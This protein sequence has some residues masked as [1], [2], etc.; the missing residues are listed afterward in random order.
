MTKLAV[1]TSQILVLVLF[2]AALG[3]QLLILPGIAAQARDLNPQVAYLYAPFLA[4]CI[5]VIACGQIVLASI[6][7]LLRLVDRDRIFTK[8]AFVWV[9]I[10]IA[11]LLLATALAG[12]MFV[13]QNVVL[14]LG[15]PPLLTYGLLAVMV[16]STTL[17]LVLVALRGLLRKASDHA[18]YLEEVV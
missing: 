6:W 9:A 15:G 7:M 12:V 4:M 16:G 18:A 11:A 5:A 10:M 1:I 2:F 3:V 8:R 13:I 14:Q 17:A